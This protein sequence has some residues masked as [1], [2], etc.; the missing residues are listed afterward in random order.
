MS[1]FPVLHSNRI[2][3]WSLWRVWVSP[4]LQA[5][6]LA[7]HSFMGTCRR[8]KPPRLETRD[9]FL[10]IA[11]EVANLSVF[12]C[13]GS[14]SCS[15]QIVM[16]RRPGEA[17]TCSRLHYRRGILGLG[18]I[19][20]LQLMASMP[21]CRSSSVQSLSRVRLFATPWTAAHQ[22]SLSITNSQSRS[23]RRRYFIFQGCKQTWPFFQGCLPHS[24]LWKDKSEQR[25]V[26]ALF[27]RHAKS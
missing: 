20:V 1:K 16:Q 3:C 7:C 21:V 9:R 23:R 17:F 15:S 5:N 8:C 6:K 10:L 26:N 27:T 11:A 14:L 18:D 22:A 24:H 19:D 25:P 4:R 12:C 2:H 13:T